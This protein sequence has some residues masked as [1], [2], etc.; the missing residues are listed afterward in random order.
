MTP[1]LFV[2][3]AIAG[4]IGAAARFVA[5]GVLRQYGRIGFPWATTAIN[6]SGSFVLGVV[7]GLVATQLMPNELGL[8]LGTGLLGGYTTFST[9]SY[10]TV[11]LLRQRRYGP[12]VLSGVGML[13]VS[14]AAA[15]VGVWV[16]GL[17]G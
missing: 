17:G 7:V 1:L 15:A 14:V 11:Q 12:A 10:E 5:D 16:G 6:V 3:I 13:V 9:A 4:G 8:V 2:A